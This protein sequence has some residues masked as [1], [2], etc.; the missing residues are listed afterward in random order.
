MTS[1][2]GQKKINFPV[3][4]VIGNGDGA[5]GN[6]TGVSGSRKKRNKT[7]VKCGWII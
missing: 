7:P 5:L 4:K 3:C 6:K 2:S 1:S